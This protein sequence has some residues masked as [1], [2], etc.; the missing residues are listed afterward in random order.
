VSQ[1]C[2]SLWLPSFVIRNADEMPQ[3]RL[4]PYYIAVDDDSGVVTWR[5]EFRSN[6]YTSLD[7]QAFV[8]F[9]VFLVLEVAVAVVVVVAWGE[10]KEQ[11][12]PPFSLSVELPNHSTTQP[13]DSQVGV[14]KYFWFCGEMREGA[15]KQTKSSLPSSPSF[16]FV[17][18]FTLAA[19][20]NP[21]AI[22]EL[23]PGTKQS[24]G[25]SG[26]GACFLYPRRERRRK[27]KE[28]K[29][30][31]PPCLKLTLFFFSCSLLSLSLSLST[32]GHA[33]GQGSPFV[34]YGVRMPL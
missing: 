32:S 25:K 17:F 11:H 18:L 4:Q 23:E 26:G 33:V 27:E 24:Q 14:F 2:D 5:M 20:R 22:P 7:V 8:S 31:S 1:C 15:G 3:G 34:L 28:R 29:C 6:F 9:L 21:S 12:S 13:F 19:P 10:E 30:F 16:S